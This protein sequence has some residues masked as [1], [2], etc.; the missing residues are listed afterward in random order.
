MGASK[1]AMKKQGAKNQKKVKKDQK[2]LKLVAAIGPS[3]SAAKQKKAKKGKKKPIVAKGPKAKFMV[4]H[5]RREKTKSG[6]TKAD[7]YYNE[8]RQKYVSVKKREQ[9]KQVF[10]RN[11]LDVWH[12]AVMSARKQTEENYGKTIGFI[13]IGGRTEVGQKLLK[14][15]QA[16]H[17]KIKLQTKW[18][19]ARKDLESEESDSSPRMIGEERSKENQTEQSDMEISSDSDKEST[20]SE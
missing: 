3:K 17:Q 19:P 9:G 6:L 13:P 11:G 1:T 2:Q 18:N 4:W 5:G 14:F 20:Y 7:L 16:E 8:K 12:E 10:K 15:V